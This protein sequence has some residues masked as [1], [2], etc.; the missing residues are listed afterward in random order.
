MKTLKYRSIISGFTAVALSVF[1]FTACEKESDNGMEIANGDKFE[2]FSRLTFNETSSNANSGTGTFN[3]GSG[4]VF[5]GANGASLTFTE[6]NSE[7]NFAD[8]KPGNFFTDPMSTGPAFGLA[9]AIGN[10][11]GTFTVGG[12]KYDY[13]FGFCAS[14]PIGGHTSLP[15]TNDVNIF[16]GIQGDWQGDDVDMHFVY[17]ISYNDATK[18][19]SFDSYEGSGAP[20]EAYVVVVQFVDD[21]QGSSDLYTYFGTSGSISYDGSNVSLTGVK[22]QEIVSGQLD[23]TEFDFSSEIECVAFNHDN[24]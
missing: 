9:G 1:L 2:K 23:P 4:N 11:G 19:G 12:T 14:Q 13:D 7:A 22:L 18:I 6:G 17:V 5:S 16:V 20:L 8:I 15:D 21:G 3:G 24:D 10:G